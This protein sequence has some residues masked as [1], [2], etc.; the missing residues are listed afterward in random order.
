MI[1]ICLRTTGLLV[2]GLQTPRSVD[3]GG[4]LGVRNNYSVV[5]L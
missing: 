1:T 2:V 4:A 3:L 5:R